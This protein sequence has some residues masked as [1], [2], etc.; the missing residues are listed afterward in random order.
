VLKKQDPSFMK[1]HDVSSLRWLFLAGEPLDEPTAR[2]ASESLGVAIVDNYWQTE[3][4]WPI[5]SAQPGV[6]DTPRKLGSP[7][8]AV[9]GYDVRLVDEAT[10]ADAGTDQK[11]VLTIAPPL[12]PGCMTTVWGDDERFVQ[13]YFSTIPA[14]C[15]TRRSTGRRATRTATTSCSDGPT[16]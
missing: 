7:S 2:W 3:T 6:E 11:G 9:Y 16:T 5:L 13:T 15:S 14:G 10:G 12:P 1:R 8:F 4:G